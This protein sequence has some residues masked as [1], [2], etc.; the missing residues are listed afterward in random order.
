[1]VV[2]RVDNRHVDDGR[3]VAVRVDEGA[4]DGRVVD[5]RVVYVHVDERVDD[6]CADDG[7]VSAGR[8]PPGDIGAFTHADKSPTA[9]PLCEPCRCSAVCLEMSKSSICE[10]VSS[11]YLVYF[12]QAR[13]GLP[14]QRPV[15][16]SSVSADVFSGSLSNSVR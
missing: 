3:V 10:R 2:R 15:T 7:P 6:R 8:T 5:A 13:N 9:P 1:V 4:D 12:R 11:V 16:L 14:V